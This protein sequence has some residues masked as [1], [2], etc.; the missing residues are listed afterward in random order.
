[1]PIIEALDNLRMRNTGR[2]FKTFFAPTKSFL[3]VGGDLL[4]KGC[5]PAANMPMKKD[6][7][8]SH[9][10]HLNQ[11]KIRKSYERF[12]QKFNLESIKNHQK[13]FTHEN[14]LRK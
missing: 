2:V 3:A 9:K 13:G 14:Q 8:S 6:K 1:M 5:V 4:V 12:L 11:K 7:F 10:D